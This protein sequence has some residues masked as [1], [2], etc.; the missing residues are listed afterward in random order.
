MRRLKPA[1]WTRVAACK[2]KTAA[3]FPEGEGDNEDPSIWDQARAIC[4]TC[5][6]SEDCLEHAI[7]EREQWGMWGGKTL[8]EREAIV[9]RRRR[10]RK[11]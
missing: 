1:A 3:M 11:G 2:H 4:L 7:R 10:E 8:K 5:T 9:R 6:V